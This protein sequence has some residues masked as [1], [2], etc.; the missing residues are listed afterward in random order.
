MLDLVIRNATIVDGSGAAAY[1]GDV[2][3]RG[4]RIEAVGEV[5][6]T[7]SRELD[8]AGRVVAPGFID[9]HTHYDAQIFWDPT[10]SPSCYH[11]V[12]TIYGGFCGFSIAPLS[13]D[14]SPYLLRMLARV[15]GMPVAALEN[16]VP[17][18]WRTFSEY[19]ERLDGRAGLNVGFM[20]G[21]SAIRCLAMGERARGGKASQ[22]DIEVMK[23]ILAEC[24]Q[25]GAMGFSSTR[26][27]THNDAEGQPVPSRFADRDEFVALASVCRAY[28]GTTLEFL[29]GAGKFTQETVQ[30]M[31]DMS[32]AAGRPLN[33]NVLG[34]GSRDFSGHQ[35]AASDFARA[36]G[37]EIIALVAAESPTLR[38]N[39][40]SGF[41]FDILDGWDAFFRLPVPERIELLK[42]PSK[43][44][45]LERRAK[46]QSMPGTN[47]LTNWGSFIVDATFDPANKP[48]EGRTIAEIAKM[49]GQGE[50]D[51]MIDIAIVDGLRTS[52]M[53]SVGEENDA[54]RSHRG[55]LWRD[56]RTVIGASDAGAHLDM[57][58]T[59]A[60]STQVLGKGVREDGIIS[61]EEAVRQITSVPARLFGLKKR[62][63][64]RPGW[65]AD[66]VVFDPKTVGRG[67]TYM[68]QDLP[69]NE[70]RI[71][72]DA[73]GIDHVF[74]NGVEIVREGRHTGALPG[75]VMRSG[76]DTE[77]AAMPVHAGSTKR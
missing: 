18:N 65:H 29:P 74:V 66:V 24:L 68:R 67:A 1:S 70:A 20:A 76:I 9:V 56:D 10:L 21:H 46:T 41:I 8:A 34:P 4:G 55:E 16:G 49:R 54:V 52:F 58:D 53:L 5:K 7:A 61:L 59:F 11:G 73:F 40:Y 43:R 35:L 27:P 75:R 6:D 71:Y 50:F 63:A 13:P 39:L 14:V 23:R 48:Y 22:D 60:F 44:M 36:H 62:G 45:E 32:V 3:I 51:A 64:L 42:N 25:Q 38:I 30:L 17:W 77:T 26:S 12:T 37:G 33:W 19:L 57:I 28:E 69:A 2:G 47:A 15:E 31:T 72:A